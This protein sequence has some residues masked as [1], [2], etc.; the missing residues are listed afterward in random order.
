MTPSVWL[1]LSA[2]HPIHFSN[3]LQQPTLRTFDGVDF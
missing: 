3:S 2:L 1:A